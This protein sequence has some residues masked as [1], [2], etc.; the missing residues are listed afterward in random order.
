MTRAVP[1][2]KADLPPLEALEGPFRE[3]LANGRITNFGR[4]VQQLEKEAG[5][6]LGGTHAVCLSSATA[7]LIM[8]LQAL[9]LPKGSRVALPSFS[10]VATAQAVLYAGCTPEF[11]EIGADGNADPADLARTLATAA[12]VRAVLLVHMYGLPCA[13]D[14]ITA[15]VGQAEKRR[16]YKIPVVYD[17]A[18]AFGSIRQGQRVGGFGDAEVFSTSVTKLM[19][20]VEGGIV[21]SRNQALIDRLKKM[22]NY[23]IESHYNAHYPGLNGK[24]SEF[25]ALVGLYNLARLDELLAARAERAAFY[26]SQVHARTACHVLVAPVGVMSTYKDFT[27]VLPDGL[28]AHRDAIIALLA[29]RGI[30]TR[31]YFHPPIHEQRFFQPFAHRPLPVTEDFSRRVIT[32]PFFSTITEDDMTAVVDGLVAA[33]ARFAESSPT[34]GVRA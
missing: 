2:I 22:R 18:H 6:Y 16:G 26:A 8:T 1:L 30:E 7:G 17:A 20:S 25:H 14:E 5:G 15:V 33:E 27:I 3:I 11:V 34:V 21:S 4:Y 12:D 32:L 13:I 28:R 9:E 10:F 29:E 23:G 31:A 24:M 19:T